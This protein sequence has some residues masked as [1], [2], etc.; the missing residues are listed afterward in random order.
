VLICAAIALP[1]LLW[2]INN[3]FPFLDLMRNVRMSNR[4]IVRGP[5][6]FVLDQ[7]AI[8]NPILV[9]LWIGGL[10]WLFF[11]KAGGRYRP[12]AW[13]YVVTLG[14]FIALKGK[15]YYVAPIYPML[16]A[17][18][19]IG[20]VRYYP[21]PV[22]IARRVMETMPHCFLVGTGAERFAGQH[23]FQTADMLT[24][25]TRQ[26]YQEW[27]AGKLDGVEAANYRRYMQSVRDL[28]AVERRQPF[29]NWAGFVGIV[30]ALSGVEAI[31]NATGVMKLDP[32]S[33]EENPSVVKTSTPA[34]LMVEIEV[35]GFTAFLGLAMHALGGME[36][37]NG[38][39]NA[40][41]AGGVRG[42]N[43]GPQA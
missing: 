25:E 17:A 12:L 5:I 38:D 2:Q 41:G 43:T 33:T 7:A 3:H 16:F 9:P 11:S 1:N 14:I 10:L 24:P 34:I 42:R 36:I 31:A 19:A 8:L 28:A 27:M 29:L 21:N 40:T 26:R 30:L 35:L 6:P 4:D 32:G 39:V 22:S 23:G 18:G 13:T 20:S 37:A 15:N